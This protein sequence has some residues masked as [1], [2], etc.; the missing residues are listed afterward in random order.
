MRQSNNEG[1]RGQAG[2]TTSAKEGLCLASQSDLNETTARKATH[3][4]QIQPASDD[5]RL[6]LVSGEFGARPPRPNARLLNERPLDRPALAQSIR[7]TLARTET[8]LPADE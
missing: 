4:H 2:P 8:I 6:P 7:H 1:R 5:N 3:A